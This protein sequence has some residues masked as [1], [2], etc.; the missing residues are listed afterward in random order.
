MDYIVNSLLDT[1]F[2]KFTMGQLVFHRYRAVPVKYAFKNRTPN[3]PLSR[4][5]PEE[6]LRRE[7]DHIKDLS[8]NNSELHYLRGTNE[9]GE[10]MFKE[11][12]LQF[13]KEFRMPEYELEKN[14]DTYL[15]EFSGPWSEAIY[16]ETFALSII[17]EL[18]YRA[19]MSGMSEFEKDAVYA[20]RTL[21]LFE[22]IKLLR[23]YPELSYCDF[24]TR[25][26]FSGRN[27]DYVV[28]VMSEEMPRSQFVGTSNT[29][30]AMKHGLVPMGT[31]AHETFMVMSGIM[32][33][34]DED[35]RKSHNKVLQD[36]WEEYGWGLSIALTDTYGTDYFFRDF[37][38]EQAR[39]WKGLRQDSGDPIEFGEK[40]INFYESRGINPK[41][42]LIVFSDGLDVN[43]MIKIYL[44]FKGRIRIT[45][46]WGTNLTNDMGFK[47][48]SLV[49]KTVEAYGNGLVKL[50]DNI[51]KA[52]GR[53]EDIAR[54]KKIFGYESDFNQECKS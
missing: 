48:L 24:G 10:R 14:G 6:N 1:D 44:H 21:R 52:L 23:Q 36:W 25:R 28:R 26:R 40:A 53:S 17:N 42:K 54:F 39:N 20:E 50:S 29:Y 8:F 35:I 15:L 41:E 30:L 22:K 47:T 9:Y 2:Y 37:T 3:I 32:Y 33:A 45:F 51:A 18:Y 31:S 4:L 19:L 43:E 13:L 11:D 34:T 7:L 27:Q 49:V 46:G 16:W 12:Y 5:I 38:E